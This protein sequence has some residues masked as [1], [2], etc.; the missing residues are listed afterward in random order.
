[1][2]KR[3]MNFDQASEVLCSDKHP[4]GKLGKPEDVGALAAFLCS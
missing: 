2:E 1:M 3:N 4:N